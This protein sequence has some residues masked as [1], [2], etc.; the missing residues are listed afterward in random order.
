MLKRANISAYAHKRFERLSVIS[1]S[2]PKVMVIT[3]SSSG[4]QAFIN[5]LETSGLE[6]LISYFGQDMVIALNA[7]HYDL[8]IVDLA[9]ELLDRLEQIRQLYALA[10][11]QQHTPILALTNHHSLPKETLMKA[12]ILA[13]VEMPCS[14]TDVYEVICQV[15]PFL[16]KY[17]DSSSPETVT[18]NQK[19]DS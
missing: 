13:N 17:L 19:K 1:S 14:K 8:V 10:P 6:V 11:Y 9:C 18:Q 7:D 16:S 15:A 3:A 2:K 4:C 5:H 12:G